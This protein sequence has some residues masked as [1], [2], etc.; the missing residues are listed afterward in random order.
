MRFLLALILC[1]SSFALVA[2]AVPG[3]VA[4]SYKPRAG[5]TVLKLEI[6]GR[7]D[8]YIKLYTKEAP[9]ATA[10]ILDLVKAKFYD[11]Q[12]FHKVDNTPKPYLVQIGD[13]ASKTGDL[14]G[15]GGSGAHIPFEDSGFSNVAGAV[16]LARPL[17]NREDGDSQFYILLDRSS[18]LDG[19]YT[20]FGQ[21]VTGMDVLKKVQRG[22]KLLKITVVPT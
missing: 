18:F 19:N 16:G 1:L 17:K 15:N 9:K 13:P 3:G 12:R 6:E 5:E 14:S 4:Q 10:H 11:G 21:V 20:V 22:D 8:V 2:A 7:G